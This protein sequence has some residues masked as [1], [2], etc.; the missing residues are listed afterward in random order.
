MCNTLKFPWKNKTHVLGSFLLQ[1][2]VSPK[3][4]RCNIRLE[5]LVYLPRKNLAELLCV[6]TFPFFSSLI[7]AWNT[8][9]Y[10]Y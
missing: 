10:L 6:C 4:V 9:F 7:I 8:C 2:V 5:N 1:D 3:F